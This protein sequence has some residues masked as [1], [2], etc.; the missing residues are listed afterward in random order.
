VIVAI[1][2]CLRR[3]AVH[4]P[5]WRAALARNPMLGGCANACSASPV[6]AVHAYPHRRRVDLVRVLF[7]RRYHP[8]RC[9][10]LHV[11]VNTL[12]AQPN[13]ILRSVWTSLWILFQDNDG[14]RCTYCIYDCDCDGQICHASSDYISTVTRTTSISISY[15]NFL[16]SFFPRK[17]EFLQMGCGC[18]RACFGKVF[19]SFCLLCFLSSTFS[20]SYHI[21]GRPR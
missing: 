4:N 21:G 3:Y 18:A 5:D 16:L 10:P 8:Q 2:P 15:T 12:H 7:S 19:L 14:N 13:G 11:S 6:A 9:M 1:V 20:C 17:P